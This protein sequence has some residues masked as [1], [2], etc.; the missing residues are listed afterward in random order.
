MKNYYA[1]GEVLAKQKYGIPRASINTLEYF[2]K[3]S[4]VHIKTS[5]WICDC[6]LRRISLENDIKVE[7]TQIQKYKHSIYL[8]ISGYKM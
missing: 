7:A 5:T 1:G 3:I 4:E 6:L 2:L 8:L